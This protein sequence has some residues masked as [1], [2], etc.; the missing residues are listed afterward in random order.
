MERSMKRVVLAYSG[1]LDTSVAI[2]WMQEQGA[3]VFPV[4]ID[5]GQQEDFDEVVARATGL[6]ALRNRVAPE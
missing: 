1:G 4:A 5:I 3:E 6:G 2:R